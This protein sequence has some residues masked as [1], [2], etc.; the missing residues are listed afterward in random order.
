MEGSSVGE[1]QEEE[2]DGDGRRSGKNY[3]SALAV[4]DNGTTWFML[5]ARSAKGKT[6]CEE[7]SLAPLGRRTVGC[8]GACQPPFSSTGDRKPLVPSDTALSALSLPPKSIHLAIFA[9]LMKGR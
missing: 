7:K 6:N 5:E 9:K 4:M 1:L 8:Y 2:E 3:S